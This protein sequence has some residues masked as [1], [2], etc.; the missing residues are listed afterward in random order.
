M[1]MAGVQAETDVIEPG[2]LTDCLPQPGDGINPPGHGVGATGG[3]L[4]QQW[5]V[6]TQPVD[7]LEPV[8]EAH[9]RVIFGRDMPAVHDQAPRA[10]LG[11]CAQV[12][13]QQFAA[14]DANAVVRRRH[15]HH[16]GGVHIDADASLLGGVLQPG[17]TPWV[18]H[19]WA[20]PA[21]QLTQ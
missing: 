10:D 4:D 12:L 9:C 3:V 6:H 2:R 16:V 11:R 18:E 1:G 8:L 19:L 14:G 17:R 7:R 21:L 15:V 13:L 20:L 5:A